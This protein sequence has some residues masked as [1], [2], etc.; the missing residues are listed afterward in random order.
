MEPEPL[1]QRHHVFL[2]EGPERAEVLGLHPIMTNKQAIATPEVKRVFGEIQAGIAL[3]ST[4]ISF[5]APPRHG[6]T[7]TCAACAT[8]LELFYPHVPSFYVTTQEHDP[9]ARTEKTLWGDW[10]EDWGHPGAHV[11]R[12]QDRRANVLSFLRVGCDRAE[13][14]QLVL[15]IDEAQ[16]LSMKAWG[17]LKDLANSLGNPRREDPKTLM[18]VSFWQGSYKPMH[19][20]L[21]RHRRQDLIGRFFLNHDRLAGVTSAAELREILQALD[22]AQ[23]MQYPIDSDVSYTQCF[24]PKAFAAGWRLASETNR[25]WKAIRRDWASNSELDVGMKGLM[26]VLRTFFVSEMKADAETFKGS[27]IKWNAAIDSCA[28]RKLLLVN[29]D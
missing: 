8:L 24:F 17:N 4:G 10:L 21:L 18:V 16:N 12:T 20:L 19:E 23:M 6:K 26:L 14:E 27:A 29:R 5:E 28:F 13:A 25:L 9:L 2:D 1:T 3:R 11:L 7:G 15:F 22:D